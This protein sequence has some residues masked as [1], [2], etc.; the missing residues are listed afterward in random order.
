MGWRAVFE[1][2]ARSSFCRGESGEW[3]ADFDWAIRA[4]G[5]KPEPALK[6]LEGSFDRT[7]GAR[8]FGERAHGADTDWSNVEPAEEDEFG[9][10]KLLRTK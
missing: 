10:V 9:N 5:K 1:R 7:P 3:V 4:E 2:I 8:K 6:I